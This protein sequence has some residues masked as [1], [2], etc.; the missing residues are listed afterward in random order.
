MPQM[1][2]RP[3]NLRKY[4]LQ[5]YKILNIEAFPER[6]NAKKRVFEAVK[7]S[8][9]ILN[10]HSQK[11]TDKFLRIH[12][13]RFVN[14]ENEKVILDIEDISLI[15]K[16]NYAIPLLRERD[17][18]LIRKIYWKSS[19]R[20]VDLGHCYTGEIDLTANKKLGLTQLDLTCKWV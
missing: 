3:S 16:A 18:N 17:L 4:L 20:M 6:D 14:I 11:S 10:L 9:C 12:S 19:V 13:D 7:M 15:D 8:V 1:S 2:T 5:N